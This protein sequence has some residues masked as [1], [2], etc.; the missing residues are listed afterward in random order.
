MKSA[1]SDNGGQNR[2]YKWASIL[3]S[4]RPGA[5]AGLALQLSKNAQ[6]DLPVMGN[7]VASLCFL[8]LRIKQRWLVL[9]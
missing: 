4:W 2:G 6:K 5:S 3:L 9:G 1:I 7:F 8:Q